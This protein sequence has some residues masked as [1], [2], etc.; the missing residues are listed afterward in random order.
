[1]LPII[2]S[3]LALIVSGA[4]GAAM[5]YLNDRFNKATILFNKATILQE[6][7]RSID[8]AKTQ[9]ENMSLAFLPI[10]SKENPTPDEKKQKEA[11]KAIY[12]SAFEK[13]LN[14]YED[15]C[16]KYY[17]DLILRDEFKRSYFGDIRKYVEEFSDKF[18][19]PV[20]CYTYML[21]LYKEWYRP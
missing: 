16:Q 10:S 11:F 2:I 4:T 14:A 5:L 9:V 19:E 20:T 3:V 8:N 17:A 15:G 12:D 6:V 7:K 18:S 1:M 13:V 21:R